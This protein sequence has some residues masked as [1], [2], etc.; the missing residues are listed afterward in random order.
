MSSSP[1]KS[2]DRGFAGGASYIVEALRWPFRKHPGLLVY[3]A[4]PALINVLLFALLVLLLSNYGGDMVAAV[5]SLLEG[6]QPWYLAWLVW[7]ARALLW[8]V[9]LMLVLA[10]SFV[11]VYVLGN[12]LAAPFNDL[13]SE[14]VERRR[15][16]G[17]EQPFSLRR[18]LED[19]GFTIREELRRLGFFLAASCL[20]L[21]LHL[22]PLVGSAAQGLLGGWLTLLFFALEYLDLPLARR[23]VG[24]R[25]RWMLVWQHRMLCTG[26]GCA[27]AVLLY[28][29][30]LNFL[31]IP[32]AVIGGT[33]M[34][35]D[36][37]EAGALEGIVTTSSPADGSSK[38]ELPA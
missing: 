14:Q 15:L 26:F 11:V 27:T 1:L 16:G 38:A 7:L 4:I 36:L 24:F 30:L 8:I 17:A 22:I 32:I 21:L 12:V 13:L 35:A 3:V 34:Y 20:L 25:K 6:D 9:L 2:L 29:P 23:R 31:C 5:E 28:I 10:V 37:L 18:L 19:I 33:L